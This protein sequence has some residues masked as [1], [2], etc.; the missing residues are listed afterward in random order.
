MKIIGHRGARGL[1]EE[2]T[3]ASFEKALALG[4][5]MVEF[6]IR[7]TKD[8]VPVAH[9]DAFIRLPDQAATV[10]IADHT[11]E[12][13]RKHKP[14]LVTMA[15]A[16]DFID[17]RIPIYLEIKPKI[18]L[19]PVIET[20]KYYLNS[21]MYKAQGI[22]IASF[23]QQVLNRMHKV[24]PD[25][26]L[27][28]NEDW[29]GVKASWRAHRLHAGIIS[30]NKR[31]LWGGYIRLASKRYDVYTFTLNDAEK[32]LRWQKDGLKGVVTDYPDRFIKEDNR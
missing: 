17:A 27:I 28:V 14:D 31:W 18:N 1:A 9:H 20:L 11:L 12:E 19:D 5:D 3:I 32:A 7:V 6:D 22:Y 15:E 8:N 23:S 21:G 30:V 4:V 2:N 26:R 25:I 29:S 16:F 13:L 24:F 10:F